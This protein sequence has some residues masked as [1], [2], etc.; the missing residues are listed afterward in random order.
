MIITHMMSLHTV[1]L[2]LSLILP[3]INS[4]TDTFVYGGC[5]QTK[6]APG[7]PYESN[8]NS[9]LTSLVNSA[10]SA[11]F[12][13]FK[14]SVPGSSPTDVVYGLFQC[15]GDLS[16]SD[17]KGCVAHAVGQLGTICME[18]LGG[19]LQLDGCFIK[20][21]NISFF[22]TE[23]KSV[24]MKRCGPSIGVDSE[25][26]TRRDGVLDSLASS[27]ADQY[28]RTGGSE[29]F[30]GV[31][32]CVQDLSTNKCQDCLTDAIGRLKSECATATWGDVFLG[33]CY[34]RFTESGSYTK[35]TGSSNDDEV[36][37]TLAILIGLIAAVALLVV[38]L[39]IIS[40]GLDS[41]GGK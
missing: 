26:L 28:F 32:Q 17:C 1:L 6:Y 41:K 20:Y 9:I 27:G 2:V 31:A 23:D 13:E 38:F 22:G 40:K 18:S 11:P 29:N 24:A 37:K 39:S 12:N 19:A 34:V 5:S 8:V 4:A 10:M 36:E 30:H 25:G 35:S 16:E 21:D 15:R 33:K 14:V 3:S 7:T